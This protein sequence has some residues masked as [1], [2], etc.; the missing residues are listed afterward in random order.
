MV[1]VPVRDKIVVTQGAKEQYQQYNHFFVNDQTNISRETH[2]RRVYHY[3]VPDDQLDE[4]KNPPRDPQDYLNALGAKD[5]SQYLEVEILDQ[6]WTNEKE[7]RDSHGRLKPSTWQ[8]KKWLVANA[9]DALLHDRDGDTSKDGATNNPADG[10]V[11]PPWR[12][13]P[14]QNI[15]NVSFTAE[16]FLFIGH[17]VSEFETS[18][19][20]TAFAYGSIDGKNWTARAAPSLPATKTTS[21]EFAHVIFHDL[22]KG[23]LILDNLPPGVEIIS[24][25]DSKVTIA[26]PLVDFPP[27]DTGPPTVT[28]DTTIPA[29]MGAQHTVTVCGWPTQPREMYL[30]QALQDLR[31]VTNWIG[32]R[33]L[34][35]LHLWKSPN[36]GAFF[37]KPKKTKTGTFFIGT[38]GTDSGNVFSFTKGWGFSKIFGSNIASLA[39]GNFANDRFFAFSQLDNVSALYSSSDGQAWAP[40]GSF[41]P[42]IPFA[43]GFDEDGPT[44]DTVKGIAYSPQ[45][46]LYVA[47]GTRAKSGD[48]FGKIQY[49]SSTSSDGVSWSTLQV[50]FDEPVSHSDSRGLAFGNGMF[51]SALYNNGRLFIS[52]DGSDWQ[53]ATIPT[54]FFSNFVLFSR[55]LKLFALFGTNLTGN[56]GM[57]L[58]SP[59]GKEWTTAFAGPTASGGVVITGAAVGKL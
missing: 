20:T 8:E 59:D 32:R 56:T 35:L 57:V 9:S 40:A 22:N 46:P 41:H 58:T 55:S 18:V 39:G 51:V 50:I 1:L 44:P 53:T 15:V 16:H 38:T 13:D 54:N 5:D 37:G 24:S 2:S 42:G 10:I 3:D 31:Q 12:L 25:T 29:L 47:V 30:T 6:F 17:V 7:S 43:N 28:V 45:I 36:N 26:I 4:N 52:P 11:D 14:L 23:D 21:T 19:D 49:I 48:S 34:R 27:Y 33:E